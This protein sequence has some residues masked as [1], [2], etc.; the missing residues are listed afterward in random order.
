MRG[1]IMHGHIEYVRQQLS[2]V[3]GKPLSEDVAVAL[4]S[5]RAMLMN[6]LRN[7]D[8]HHER[9]HRLTLVGEI[10]QHLRG[11]LQS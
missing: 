6:G 1:V 11:K 9:L 4:R 2:L 3:S 8:D 5:M 10:D 7:A